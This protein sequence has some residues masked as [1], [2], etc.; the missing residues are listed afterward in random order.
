MTRRFCV[1]CGR[2]GEK[3]I[4][5]LCPECYVE[6]EVKVELPRQ[7]RGYVCRECR[8]M[9]KRGRWERR[10]ESLEE[11]VEEA[12]FSA[13]EENLRVRGLS[14]PEVGIAFLEARRS[15]PRD[16]TARYR[17]EVRGGA[18]GE[19]VELSREVEAGVRLTLCESCQRRA[20]RY[21]EAVLQI[22]AHA[23]LTKEERE[24]LS[25]LVRSEVERRSEDKAFISSYEERREGVDFYLGSAKLAKK[26]ANL[27]VARYGGTVTTSTK[28]VG[29]DESGRN[30]LRYTF[31]YRLPRVRR[32]DVI[33]LGDRVC[34]VLRLS[35]GSVS[36]LDLATRRSFSLPE[37][38]LAKA[39]LLG[40][41]EDAV[42]AMVTE[43]VKDRIQVLEFR[44]YKTFYFD[45]PLPLRV[46]DEVRLLKAEGRVY[47]LATHLE[48]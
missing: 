21:Y 9:L 11:A 19:E 12:G 34:Q 14:Q 25:R 42:R 48:E 17:L 31:A 47:L 39:E 28:L 8:A 1:R 26:I 20:S 6:R 32:G 30:V 2:R 29:V 36:L 22:R 40:S 15:S 37:K 38:K 3:L 44:D 46:G 5:A 24:E 33:R 4:G 7:L 35:R 43:V 16:Y 13:I 41:A 23:P 18:G 27:L 10:A 45:I